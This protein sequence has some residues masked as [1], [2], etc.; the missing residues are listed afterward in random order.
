MKIFCLIVGIVLSVLFIILLFKGSKEDQ[1]L[2]PLEG[3]DFPLKFLYS[4]GLAWQGVSFMRLR[5][6]IGRKLHTETALYYDERYSEYYSRIIWAQV[7]SFAHLFLAVF[8]LL[9]AGG[10]DSMT[11]FYIAVGIAAG[12]LSAYYFLTHAGEK[13]K[14]MREECEREFPNAIS[15]LALL[16]NSG[17]ILHDAWEMVAGGKT[18]TLYSIMQRAC[19]EMRNGKSVVDAIEKFGTRTDSQEIKKFTSILIQSVEKGGGE[20]PYFL[21][22]QSSELWAFKRQLMLQKG[23]KAAGALLAPVGL[24]FAGVMLIVLAAAMQSFT[25]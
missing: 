10:D 24:M 12:A 15:K 7:L 13:V 23:E 2:D 8:F 11:L 14:R 5:G 17:M 21:A 9:A 4:A 19:D 22:R 3:E 20:L 16:V 25:M 1:M 6:R 18:G